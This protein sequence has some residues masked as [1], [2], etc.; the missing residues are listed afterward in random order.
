MGMESFTSST[1]KTQLKGREVL[2]HTEQE[3]APACLCM[4]EMVGIVYLLKGSGVT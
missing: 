3:T 4:V 1:L 2:N